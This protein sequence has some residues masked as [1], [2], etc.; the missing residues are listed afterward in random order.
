MV[1]SKVSERTCVVCRRREQL[2]RPSQ[3]KVRVFDKAF[4]SRN[5]KNVPAVLLRMVILN[6]E[7]TVEEDHRLKGRGAYV[8]CSL[9]CLAKLLQ[10]G[11]LSRALRVGEG[12]L[13]PSDVRKVVEMLM[14][15]V[16]RS[17]GDGSGVG[18]N[19]DLRQD[20]SRRASKAVLPG[21]RG[22]EIQKGKGRVRL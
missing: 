4:L 1:S 11:R 21:S 2:L 9:E 15:R 12:V 14:E 17:I 19:N 5:P 10:A 18:E 3:K 7:L 6:G 13:S 20:A 22:G 16:T 8:H